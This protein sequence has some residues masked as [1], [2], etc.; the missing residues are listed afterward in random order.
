MFSEILRF[1]VLTEPQHFVRLA[2]Q[3]HP[4]PADTHHANL[5]MTWSLL[6]TGV[7]K[8]ELRLCLVAM[9]LAH[10][11]ENW[12]QC[13]QANAKRMEVNDAESPSTL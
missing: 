1:T 6:D 10:Y 2:A 12:Q 3:S 11:S 8:L 9:L 13:W 7:C 4:H 5:N